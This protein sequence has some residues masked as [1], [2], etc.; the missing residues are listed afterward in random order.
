MS[1]AA[2]RNRSNVFRL[3]AF[4]Q[5]A[6]DKYRNCLKI[7]RGILNLFALRQAQGD[8]QVDFRSELIVIFNKLE[9]R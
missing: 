5:A 6:N 9:N 7:N 3:L 8:N 2:F 1:L 4:L